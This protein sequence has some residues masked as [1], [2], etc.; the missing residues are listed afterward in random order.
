MEDL[1]KLLYYP[2]EK[3]P[4][5]FY[6]FLVLF[7]HFLLALLTKRTVCFEPFPP[8]SCMTVVLAY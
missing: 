2:E 5:P 4:L 6:T 1:Q 7:I 8:R 3:S